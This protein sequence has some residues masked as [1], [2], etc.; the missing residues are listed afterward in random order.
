MSLSKSDF[1]KLNERLK[2]ITEQK[3]EEI[4]I[5]TDYPPTIELL[6][7]NK[8]YSIKVHSFCG[9]PKIY[10]FD[11]DESSKKHGKNIS[12]IYANGSRMRP[13]KWRCD[14][15]FFW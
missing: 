8:T 15:T 5:A 7:D 1:E 3:V 11:R 13:K 14:T 2:K 12:F 6:E 10:I 4:D 9:R